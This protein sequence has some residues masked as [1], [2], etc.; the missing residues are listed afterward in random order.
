MSR[1][2]ALEAMSDAQESIVSPAPPAPPTPQQRRRKIASHT[3]K[4]A[5]GLG[6]LAYLLYRYDIAEVYQN[7][8]SVNLKLFALAWAYS[9]AAMTIYAY[10]T[11]VGMRPLGMPLTTIDILKVQFQVRFYSLF[12][13][14]AANM[15]VKWYKFARPAK[16]PAQALI[17]MGFTRLLHTISLM[18]ITSVGIWRDANFPWPPLQWVAIASAA[19]LIVGMLVFIS[20]PGRRLAAVLADLP[21]VH[22]WLPRAIAK[23][24]QKL[25]HITAQLQ[26]VSRREIAFLVFLAIAGNS[27]ET[28]QH[29]AIG[30]AVGLELSVWVYAWLRGVILIAAMVPFSLAGLGVREA[31]VVGIL[32]F[33]A[34]PEEQAL[35]YSL[36]FFG[37][38]VLGK[39]LIGGILELIDLL[40]GARPAPPPPT[41][42]T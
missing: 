36:L 25:W 23:K 33:Y 2:E 1:I 5:I 34:V 42:G 26:G 39:G 12:M 31:S 27:L 13:P 41:Q 9:L 3:I 35:A 29:L 8:G 16:Q 4:T 17:I 7:L 20:E 38:F 6:I 19:A 14:G 32:I 30:Q 21:L 10:M 37:G 18:L 40:R 11:R 22:R 15:L 28:L 24:W